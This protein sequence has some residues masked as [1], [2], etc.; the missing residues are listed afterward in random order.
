MSTKPLSIVAAPAV[1][2]AGAAFLAGFA[3][4]DLWG[5]SA[6]TYHGPVSLALCL[7]LPAIA[8][9]A[10]IR[11]T[12][13]PVDPWRRPTVFALA[14]AS[15]L[16]ALFVAATS[17]VDLLGDGFLYIR[18]LDHAADPAD[19][20]RT[21]RAPLTF[22]LVRFLTGWA[23][24]HDLGADVVYRALSYA[25]GFGYV[26]VAVAFC[27]ATADTARARTVLLISLLTVGSIQLFCGYAE[28]YAILHLGAMA[29]LLF[30]FTALRTGRPAWRAAACLGVL[31][32]VHLS[33]GA[34]LP[35]LLMLS[36]RRRQNRLHAI[37]PL[38]VCVAIAVPLLA[39]SGFDLNAFLDRASTNRLSLTET[40]TLRA[41]GLLSVAHFADWLNGLLL[42]VPVAF[43]VFPVH[44]PRT[45]RSSDT[46]LL[47]SIALPALAFTFIANPEIGAFRDWDVL[48]LPAIP[49]ATWAAFA[50]LRGTEE[51]EGDRIRI[52]LTWGPAAA[53]TLLWVVLNATPA[54][55]IDRYAD[56]LSRPGL[57]P[58][59]RSYGWET[60]A[61]HHKDGGDTLAAREAFD[62]AIDATPWKARLWNSVGM[63]EIEAG[64]FEEARQALTESARIEPYHGTWFNIGLVCERLGRPKRAIAAYTKAIDLAPRNVR[65]LTN[66]GALLAKTGRN[67]AAIAAYRKALTIRPDAPSIHNNL[68]TAYARAGQH[69]RAEAAYLAA[70]RTSPTFAQPYEN[71]SILYATLGDRD[72]SREMHHRAVILASH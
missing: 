36:A 39:A 22:V 43:L 30:A 5:L 55:A 14:L 64:R 72:R 18:E 21:D 48:S 1:A 34:L 56:N 20:P 19:I 37:L 61:L 54:A 6:W 69:D 7:G 58:H 16:T 52:A 24:S 35:S 32:P 40:G 51:A 38:L 53:C 71:L 4:A 11:T 13:Q 41:Y 28:N 65:A 68:G 25:S 27:R 45:H 63:M 59:A 10:A 29:Y 50:F 62:R 46:R 3:P 17:A 44:G 9:L 33:S 47:A 15:L 57:A 31:L 42:V 26:C 2:L 12:R 8:C 70:I 66:L 49:L 23:R 60:L 67:H